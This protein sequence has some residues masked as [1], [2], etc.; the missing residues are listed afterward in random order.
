MHHWGM[1]HVDSPLHLTILMHNL[2]WYSSILNECLKVFKLY[3]VSGLTHLVRLAKQLWWIVLNTLSAAMMRILPFS[4]IFS[5]NDIFTIFA[6]QILLDVGI[7]IHAVLLFTDK[8]LIFDLYCLETKFAFDNKA[9]WLHV[10]YFVK[11]MLHLD[12]FLKT[13]RPSS[14]LS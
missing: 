3:T 6:E 11:Y 8:S 5:V 2:A 12:F 1:L 7:F 9:G 10:H 4:L 13:F 14:F